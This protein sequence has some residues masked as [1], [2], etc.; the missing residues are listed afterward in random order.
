MS[1]GCPFGTAANEVSDH[2]ELAR[3]DLDAIFDAIKSRLAA[4]FIR[5]KS[6][7]RLVAD[8]N[9]QSLADFCIATIQG[10]MLLGKLRRSSDDAEAIVRQALAHIRSYFVLEF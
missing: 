3:Q 8:A 1:R 2:E 7:R 6:Q 9:E 4:F 5:E 10:A